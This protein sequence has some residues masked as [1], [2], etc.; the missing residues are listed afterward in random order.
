MDECRLLMAEWSGEEEVK[1]SL[2]LKTLKK[3]S[4]QERIK[5]YLI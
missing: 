4:E 5:V 2:D 3:E 1:A